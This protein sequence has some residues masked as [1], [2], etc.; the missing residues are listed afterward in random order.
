MVFSIGIIPISIY[1]ERG[2]FIAI[3]MT[4]GKIKV[5]KNYILCLLRLEKTE[6]F[7]RQNKFYFFMFRFF[8]TLTK[9]MV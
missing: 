3:P 9:N 4:T 7:V 2:F 1:E 5:L 6:I 8:Q